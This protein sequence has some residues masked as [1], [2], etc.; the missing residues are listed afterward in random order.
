MTGIAFG[1]GA[2]E[3]TPGM[4]PVAILDIVPGSKRE[5]LVRKS[6]TAP[7]KCIDVMAIRAFSTQVPL[8][9]IGLCGCLVISH[10]TVDTLHTQ[11][12]E[13]K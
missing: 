8:H 10:V 7:G 12:F 5:E 2:C 6:R 11:R 13:P 1:R 4:T 3:V 9:V